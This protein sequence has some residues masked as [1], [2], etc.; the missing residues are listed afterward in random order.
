MADRRY[1][2]IRGSI[3]K[4]DF[5]QSPQGGRSVEIRLPPRSAEK[6]SARLIGSDHINIRNT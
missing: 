5:Y 6:H 4:Q 1:P 2:L 3:Y